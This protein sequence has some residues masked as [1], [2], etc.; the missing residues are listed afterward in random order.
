MEKIKKVQDGDA[1]IRAWKK[2]IT[3]PSGEDVPAERSGKLLSNLVQDGN[4]AFWI[5]YNQVKPDTRTVLGNI[6]RYRIV[7]QEK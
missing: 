4:G 3:A 6:A 1:E 7:V 5:L 2:A